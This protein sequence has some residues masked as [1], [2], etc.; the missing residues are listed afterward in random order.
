MAVHGLLSP[1]NLTGKTGSKKEKSLYEMD[2]LAIPKAGSSVGGTHQP[3]LW[4]Q[5]AAHDHDTGEQLLVG[6]PVGGAHVDCWNT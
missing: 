4:K 5:R 2:R 6:G 1:G 3:V